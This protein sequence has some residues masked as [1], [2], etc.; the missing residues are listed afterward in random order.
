VKKVKG[1]LA[2]GL[3]LGSL[4]FKVKGLTA[5]QIIEDGEY[6]AE[7][8]ARNKMIGFI[9]L[10]P[11][12]DE[13]FAIL[14]ALYRG[15][16]PKPEEGLLP[17]ENHI[18]NPNTLSSEHHNFVMSQWHVDNPFLPEPPSFTSM[19][20]HT[21]DLPK[22]VGSTYLASLCLMYE[23]C[24]DHFKKELELIKFVHH[25]GSIAPCGDQGLVAH[26]A[27][28][29]HPVT[30]ET[31]IFWTGPETSPEVECDWF[32]AFSEWVHQYLSDG[33]NWYQW[34][35]KVGD[36]IVWDNRATIHSFG[37]GW[38]HSQRIFARGSIG[39]EM[40]YFD[41][42][43]QSKL[44]P[45]FGD[46]IRHHTVAKDRSVGPNPDH[47][48]LVFTKGIYALPGLEHRFQKATM[49]VYSSN[50]QIPEDAERVKAETWNP[51]FDIIPVSP[52]SGNFLERYSKRA[53]PGAPLEGQKFLFTPNGDLEKAYA[54]SD[55]LFSTELDDQGRWPLLRLIEAFGEFH[56]DLRHAGHAWH[57]PD[58]FPHQPLKNRPWDWHNLSFIDYEGFEDSQPPFD[59][60]VQFAV[61]TV[62]GC[63][64]HL[65]T[66][67]ER[68]EIIEAIVDYLQYML[69]LNEHEIDR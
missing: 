28:R 31:M 55:D 13:H 30:G 4:G 67:E 66:N 40:P 39:E 49:F 18:G 59:F 23:M 14:H 43:R 65:E 33:R 11:T 61:D 20:M 12:Q 57:Y 44:N 29:T 54:P 69:E 3:M 24:P 8:L 26:P 25:T 9:G 47:I 5:Q 68:K 46:V 42:G 37:P 60:L 15:D 58:W 19:H 10:H 63:F 6:F 62:Y 64:N 27:L 21:F 32:P 17:N 45:A 51:E 35:W 41:P 52:E 22:G 7:I 34:D 36:F 56:A 1:G 53:L 48:P 16:D 2:A 38:N 50:G